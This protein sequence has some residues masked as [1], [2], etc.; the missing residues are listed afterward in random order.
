MRPSITVPTTKSLHT[1]FFSEL[2]DAIFVS[3]TK[4]ILIVGRF[5]HVDVIREDVDDIT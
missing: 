4:K 5:A 3:A 2:L 1:F